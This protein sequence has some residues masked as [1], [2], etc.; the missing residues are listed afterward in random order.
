MAPVDNSLRKCLRSVFGER[1]SRMRAMSSCLVPQPASLFT[2]SRCFSVGTRARLATVC[3]GVSVL[4]EGQFSENRVGAEK[5]CA[6]VAPLCLNDLEGVAFRI[7]PRLLSR[8]RLPPPQN[9]IYVTRIDLQ[10]ITDAAGGLRCQQCGA[11]SQK[12]IIDGF[13]DLGV[14]ADGSA[15]QLQRFLGAVTGGGLIRVSAKG[16]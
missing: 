9:N 7:Q 5:P 14:V 6:R 12:R 2:S 4:Y 8:G 11:R 16:I 15:H 10:A 3:L 13:A 1:N